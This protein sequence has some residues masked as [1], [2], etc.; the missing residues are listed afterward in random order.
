MRRDRP[1]GL[2]AGLTVNKAMVAVLT[3]LTLQAI[4][5]DPPRFC[6]LEAGGLGAPNQRR[7]SAGSCALVIR[8]FPPEPL[9]NVVKN[10]VFLMPPSATAVAL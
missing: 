1:D 2:A 10:I 4:P 6:F 8:R 7:T 5:P 3:I 9:Q